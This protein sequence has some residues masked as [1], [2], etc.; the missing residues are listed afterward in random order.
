MNRLEESN[1][2]DE[3]LTPA[4]KEKKQVHDL[5]NPVPDPPKK[6]ATGGTQEDTV[7]PEPEEAQ[8]YQPPQ[9]T[10]ETQEATK[11]FDPKPWKHQ[12][13]HLLELI[14]RDIVK[15]TQIRSQIKN[16]CAFHAFLYT[17]E[18]KDRM[19]AL[20]EANWINSIQE[21]LNEFQMIKVWHLEN[22]RKKQKFIRLKW[23]FRNKLD[24]YGT[25]VRNK[26]RPVAKGHYQQEGI[27]FDE[28]FAH[29]ARI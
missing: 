27:D 10:Q 3:E 1:H 8:I 23:V 6:Q 21:E 20:K 19:E 4:G 7:R 9:E 11:S 26:V 29:V 15:G 18:P 12:N 28:T 17:I 16:F 22:K 5:E 14:K 25:V 2:C 24:E 13:S